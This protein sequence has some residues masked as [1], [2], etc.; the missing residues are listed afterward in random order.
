MDWSAHARA[1]HAK[2][3]SG[4]PPAP[5]APS[6]LTAPPAPRAAPV[7]RSGIDLQGWS[8]VA[9]VTL[10]AGF[11]GG[12][13]TQAQVTDDSRRQP[14]V[15]VAGPTVTASPA[16]SPGFAPVLNPLPSGMAGS[17]TPTAV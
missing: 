13:Y 12:F 3:S 6:R 10:G 7:R 4:P 11:A 16:G 9:V 5:G 8:A 14:A 2:P 15:T 17:P 1:V